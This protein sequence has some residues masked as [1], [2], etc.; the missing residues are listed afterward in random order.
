MNTNKE[1]KELDKE[2]KE[3]IPEM[4]ELVSGGCS[5]VPYNYSVVPDKPDNKPQSGGATGGW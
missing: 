5:D 4:M 2:M 1:K 3:Q